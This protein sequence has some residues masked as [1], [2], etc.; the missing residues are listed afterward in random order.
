[1]SKC[2]LVDTDT[3]QKVTDQQISGYLSIRIH[4]LFWKAF[5]LVDFGNPPVDAKKIRPNAN[6]KKRSTRVLARGWEMQGHLT[7]WPRPSMFIY[8][9]DILLS[10]GSIFHI[11]S[12]LTHGASKTKQRS[13]TAR[14]SAIASRSYL[15]LGRKWP[16]R[17]A[18]RDSHGSARH[19][20]AAA[21]VLRTCSG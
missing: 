2:Y 8:F 12:Q 1:V 4:A 15:V 5:F 14:P 9:V 16:G 11:H 17:F 20:R 18:A 21:N 13:S 6:S 10:L 3:A 19:P 7:R